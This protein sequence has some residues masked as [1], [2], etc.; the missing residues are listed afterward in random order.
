MT[1]CPVFYFSS[2][3]EN[4][5]TYIQVNLKNNQNNDPSVEFKSNIN[6]DLKV[7]NVDYVLSLDYV[8]NCEISKEPI[9]DINYN[10][11]KLEDI[12]KD[13]FNE[14]INNLISF[15]D[16]FKVQIKDE[17]EYKYNEL[18]EL[19]RKKQ[20]EELKAKELLEQKQREEEELKAKEI[21]K[22]QE[23]QKIH[24][25]N[26]KKKEEETRRKYNELLKL[27]E[28]T[29]INN[30]ENIIDDLNSKEHLN[31]IEDIKIYNNKV[32]EQNRKLED[33]EKIH[34]DVKSVIENLKEELEKLKVEEDVIE[35]INNTKEDKIKYFKEKYNIN[36]EA[37]PIKLLREEQN[38]NGEKIELINSELQ[39]EDE[40]Y[41]QLKLLIT[42]DKNM[43][44]TNLIYIITQLMKFVENFNM[45]GMDKKTLIIETI[46][47]F[48]KYENMN[49]EE[50]DIILDKVCPEL[51]DILLLVDKRK[52]IIRKKLNCF[53]PWCI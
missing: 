25:Y 50:I 7:D 17:V 5:K 45:D 48:L 46:K 42:D 44:I 21:L 53:I 11:I 30:F 32:I 9:T 3:K 12:K 52:I 49:S 10:L 51:I 27:D 40:L 13:I 8:V 33:E 22:L 18:L 38:I 34:L 4:P 36:S 6:I 23:E 39:I 43:I 29:K 37:E 2:K 1:S 16:A 20:E 24:E 19:E 28:E 26:E 47:K 31:T 15:M 35:D 41:E 14:S